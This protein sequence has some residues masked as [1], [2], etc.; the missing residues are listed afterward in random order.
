[1]EWNDKFTK[2]HFKKGIK[3]ETSTSPMKVNL[4]QAITFS[5][6]LQIL[7]TYVTKYYIRIYT[8]FG[9]QNNLMCIQ[10]SKWMIKD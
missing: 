10:S 5:L 1:M 3:K 7:L 2:L 9:V 6:F 8:Q 4:Q